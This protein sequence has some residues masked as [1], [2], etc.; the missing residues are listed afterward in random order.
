[1]LTARDLS[2][3]IYGDTEHHHITTV[4]GSLESLDK[5][6]RL[7]NR[8]FFRPE[9]YMGRGN[10]PNAS[11]LSDK[12]VQFAEEEWPATYPKEFSPT[13]SPHTIE[14]DL[15][16]AR[17]HITLHAL[18]QEKDWQLGWKK[19][20]AHGLKPD[21]IFEITNGKTAHFFLEEEY[22]RKDFDAL[23]TKFKP[24]VDLHGTSKMK[25]DWGFRYY[26]VIV[27]MRD[28]NA[29]QNVIAHFRGECNCVDRKL[30]KMH[31]SARYKLATDI[32]AFTTHADIIERPL[33][34][35]FHTPS[36]KTLS[37]LEIVR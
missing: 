1:M 15:R 37:L 36:G 22:K 28:Q 16:R 27:P 8:I 29:V 34:K 33:D 5:Q 7:I 23:Y 20:D 14:H 4:N 32:L 26:N 10:L 25:E 19:G 35:I 9:N 17:T 24:Y 18:A 2:Q 31:G 6:N 30:K 11:G 13:H 3:L 12:G 21:D